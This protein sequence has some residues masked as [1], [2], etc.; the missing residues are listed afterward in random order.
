MKPCIYC[1]NNFIAKRK[2]SIFCSNSC[3]CKAYH[4]KNLKSER[5]RKLK[6]YYLEKDSNYEKL[7][8]INKKASQKYKSLHKDNVRLAGRKYQQ[9][10][11]QSLEYHNQIYFGGNRKKILA[12]Y[13]N[14]CVICLSQINLIIHH[15]DGSGHTDNINNELSNL[16]VMCRK[17]HP[18]YH[19]RGKLI[20]EDIV[21]T[22]VR[23]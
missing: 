6:L 14:T 13:K 17:C 19:Y 21:R 9:R 8:A 5:A 18:K 4:Q 15:I 1:G 10:T 2:D 12:L 3:R 22:Y 23:A 16:I 20:D 7:R 11:K